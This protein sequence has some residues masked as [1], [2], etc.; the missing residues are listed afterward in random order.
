MILTFFFN[1]NAMQPF[2]KWLYSKHFKIIFRKDKPFQ[3][4]CKE[5]FFLPFCI[6]YIFKDMYRLLSKTGGKPLK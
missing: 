1:E 6:V 2:I 5:T 4:F 3:K